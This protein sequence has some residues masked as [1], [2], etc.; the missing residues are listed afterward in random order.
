MSTMSGSL[1]RLWALV[2]KEFI[3]TFRDWRTLLIQ[4]SIPLVQL[5]L[6]GYAVDM[7]VE[8][9]PTVVADQ[10]LD[11]AS[12]AYL[13]A[14][15]VSGYFDVVE[16]VS[17]QTEVVRVI[18]EGRAQAGVF[19]PPNF[20]T[21]QERGEAQVLL[22]VDGSDI[23]T[24]QSAY[25]A[26]N[27]IAQ[28]YSAEVLM[29]KVE[30]SGVTADS[31]SLSPIDVL[32]R[33]LYNPNLSDLWFM[34]PGIAATLLQTQS[35]ALT[36]AAVVRE[37]ESGTIEQILVTPIK[38]F[39]LMLGKIAPNLLIAMLNMLTIVGLG[40]FWFKVPFR[41]DFWLF[42]WLAFMYV[43]SGLG[44]GL[45]ISTVSQNQ[46]QT[47]Q[48]TSL[49]ILIGTMLTGFIFPR[50]TMPRLI[51]FIGNLFPMNYFIP[52]ARGIISKGIGIEF[53]WDQ[54]W[55]LGFYIVVVMV[56]AARAFRQDLE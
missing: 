36:A 52:I 23:F 3:Q 14:V 21:R 51:Q 44:L 12:R 24:A 45:L 42:F 41:G 46:K 39:E 47:Q 28:A 29:E 2:Q 50:Y 35:I 27:A 33:I 48:T 22:L 31:P 7:S 34:I 32:I 49:L 4:L 56:V 16:Y 9:I 30:S 6:F 38:P 18:D 43:F 53:L 17:N 10:S 5:F 40:I 11:P 54:V 19:I 15:V 20:A 25:N 55:A 1:K 26:A 8:H 37:R 13:D